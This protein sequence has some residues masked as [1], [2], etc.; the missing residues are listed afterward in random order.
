[1]KDMHYYEVAPTQIIRATSASFTYASEQPLVIGQLVSI[2]VGKKVFAGII[3]AGVKKPTYDT[4][5]ILAVIEGTS[6]PAPLVSLALWLSSYYATHLATVLQ[7]MLPRGIQKNRRASSPES[8]ER[9][10]DRT[11][12]V[13]NKD[14]LAA[15]E[16]IHKMSPGSALL[17][18]ITGSGKTAV[19]IE[20]A[21][22]TLAAGKS[23]I[24]LVP[25]IALTS[26]I[27]DELSQH[28]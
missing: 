20:L 9:L 6:L 22:Q 7:I 19:Y 16:T 25:E 11:K 24:V 8:K 15:V 18:G 28:F 10:R 26:Q 5:Q 27:V 3:I 1:M 4:K 17:H 23:V 14:Q 2:E 12:N 13:L 21:R